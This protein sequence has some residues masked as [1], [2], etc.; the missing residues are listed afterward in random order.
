MTIRPTVVVALLLTISTVTVIARQ[1]GPT[2]TVIR[3]EQT[4]PNR[5]APN[6]LPPVDR[7]FGALRDIA[8]MQQSWLKQRL[9]T[10]LPPLMRKHGIDLWVVPMR[11]YNEDPVFWSIT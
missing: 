4:V 9:D 10:F 3:S 11:E 1:N 6:A 5:L 7:P 8:T 2:V